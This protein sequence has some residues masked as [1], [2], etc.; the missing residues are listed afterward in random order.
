MIPSLEV[1]R[2]IKKINTRIKI[3]HGDDFTAEKV[4]TLHGNIKYA[5]GK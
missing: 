2:D 5:N 1:T 3:G 4:G